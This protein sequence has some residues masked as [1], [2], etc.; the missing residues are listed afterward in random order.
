MGTSLTSILLA[1]VQSLDNKVDEIRARVIFQRDCYILCFTETW[2]TQD[3]LSESIKPPSFIPHRAAR[4][5][6][7]SGKKEGGGV[8]L[9]IAP[10]VVN[11]NNIQELKSFCSPDL[12]FLTIKCRPHYLPREFSSLIITA[13][14]TP[15]P[16]EIPQSP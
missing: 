5:K 13:I 11:H 6:H 8:C 15:P 12:E 3:M 16:K 9:M 2:L 4:N 7:L 14:Y 10:R 1:N